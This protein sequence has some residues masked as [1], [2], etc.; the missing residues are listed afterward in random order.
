MRTGGCSRSTGSHDP[1]CSLLF[2]AP[3]GGPHTKSAFG[4]DVARK[5][6][7]RT[8]EDPDPA[9]RWKRKRTQR[10]NAKG[11]L[12]YCWEWHFHHL[13]HHAAIHH[14]DEL[15]LP[16][17]DAAV[18]LGNT[19]QLLMSRYYGTVEGALNRA[20]AASEHL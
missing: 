14:L 7:E 19:E 12:V 4:R 16:P 10:R 18:L 17:A 5:A 6:F 20:L 11:Q 2:P 15:R 13:R 1:S 3:T 9:L 8:L